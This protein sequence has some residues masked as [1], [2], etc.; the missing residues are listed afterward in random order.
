MSKK[1]SVFSP[2]ADAGTGSIIETLCRV[3]E[4]SLVVRPVGRA[5]RSSFV[6]FGGNHLRVSQFSAGVVAGADT[7]ITGGVVNPAT[8]EAEF[9]KLSESGIP[10]LKHKI[11]INYPVKIVTPYHTALARLEILSKSGSDWMGDE[12]ALYE[13]LPSLEALDVLVGGK[14]LRS[15]VD[16]I[17]ESAVKASESIPGA[18]QHPEITGIFAADAEPVVDELMKLSDLATVLLGD[19]AFIGSYNS[20]I[21]DGGHR[22]ADEVIAVIPT[23]QTN[24][25][26]TF[27]KPTELDGLDQD[28]D[29]RKS[30]T[31]ESWIG[32]VVAS[33]VDLGDKLAPMDATHLAVTKCDKLGQFSTWKYNLESKPC[34]VNSKNFI[35][36]ISEAEDLPVKIESHGKTYQ[37]KVLK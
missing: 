28:N 19:D 2:F 12:L 5:D 21:Y 10:D 15:R 33:P 25:R 14:R 37:H 4:T 24:R 7:L 1:I 31:E 22:P 8:L 18:D 23:Y 13:K 20:I 3:N 34:E 36:T 27:K 32:R 26:K 30:V 16:E 35:Q 29:N 6:Q 9:M 11:F 17:F